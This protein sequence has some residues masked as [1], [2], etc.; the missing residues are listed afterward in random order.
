[1]ATFVKRGKKWFFIVSYYGSDG[2]R[3]RHEEYG[4]MTKDEAERTFRAHIRQKDETGRYVKP[5]D[6][7][8]GDFLAEWLEKQVKVNGK[9]ATYNLYKGLTINH[10]N[11]AFGTR[12]LRDIRTREL[13]DWLIGLK[14]KGSSKS[15]VKVLLS[16]LRSAGKW[17]VANREYLTINPAANVSLPRFDEAPTSPGVFTS[18]EIA[19]IFEFYSAGSKL[20][21]PIRIAYYTGMRKG[22]VLALKWSDID[23]FGRSITVSKTLYNGQHNAPKTKGSYRQVSFGQKLMSDLIKQK[24]WQEANAEAWGSYYSPS[25]YVCTRE[26]G[27]QMTAN[28]IRAFEKYCKAHFGGHSFHTFRH[29]HA[30]RLLASGQFTLEYVA[31]RLGHSSLATTAN[32]YYNVTK[33]EAR[34]A[35][36]KMEDIL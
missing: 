6:I 11:P 32:I 5:P 23:L 10:I 14:D 13:Q 21:I 30:T 9:P 29:T 3:H 18:D 1:M 28:D 7:T 31:K 19:E 25:P 33:D 26:D 17:A 20:F 2:V 35:A 15:T 16:I 12:R 8:V 36:D 24:H 4:G 34:Q 27:S 22:E